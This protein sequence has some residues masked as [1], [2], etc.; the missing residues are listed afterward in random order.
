MEKPDVFTLFGVW[1]ELEG[2]DLL[3]PG[4]SHVHR[5]SHKANYV[6]CERDISKE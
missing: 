4:F 6:K 5:L 2:G 1:I 3:I